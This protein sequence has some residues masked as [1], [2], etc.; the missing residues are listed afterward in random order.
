MATADAVN[1]S[2]DPTTIYLHT[3]GR[4]D[5]EE[6]AIPPTA[7]LEELLV[8]SDGDLLWMEE[9]EE[10]PLETRITVVE[11][12]IGAGHHIFRG[13][14]RQVEVSVSTEG[15]EV[16]RSSTPPVRAGTVAR[17]AARALGLADADELV[18]I[19]CRSG[20]VVEARTHIGSLAERGDCSVELELERR[21]RQVEIFVNTRPH[22]VTAAEISFD[23]VVKL[24]Y[25]TPPPGQRIEYDVTYRH[26]PPE[27]PKGTLLEGH[28][29]RIRNG[30]TFNVT[31]TDKS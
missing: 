22:V 8:D 17:W 1:E 25:P 21:V 4:A 10:T 15:R 11:A 19:D 23:T 28:S 27:H 13:P 14:C 5:P 31:A 24:A 30:M 12:R 26:G 29:V 18:I 16:A 7:L 3:L 2:S 20:Q 6:V 9:E